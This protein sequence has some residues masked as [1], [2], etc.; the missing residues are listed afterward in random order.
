M[1]KAEIEQFREA[2]AFLG[3][4]IVDLVGKPGYADRTRVYGIKQIGADGK[5]CCTYS[6]H[7]QLLDWL[8]YKITS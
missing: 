2:L 1:K 7:D 3:F 4:E 6:T 5:L 8:K